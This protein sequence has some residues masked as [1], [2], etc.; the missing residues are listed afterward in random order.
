M[1]RVTANA[2]NQESIRAIVNCSRVG[3]GHANREQIAMVRA[4]RWRLMTHVREH[5]NLTLRRSATDPRNRSATGMV[6]RA[7]R[8]SLLAATPRV[9]IETGDAS[10]AQ[11]D[12]I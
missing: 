10:S 1:I 9:A 2:I 6:T 7:V 4:Q 11:T 3:R 8:V 5:L 12:H